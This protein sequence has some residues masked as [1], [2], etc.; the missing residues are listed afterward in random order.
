MSYRG[1]GVDVARTEPAVPALPGMVPSLPTLPLPVVPALPGM[2]STA[3]PGG[4]IVGPP[5]DPDPNAMLPMRFFGIARRIWMEPP[6]VVTYGPS[7]TVV[8]YPA[9]QPAIN[10]GALVEYAKIT[11]I[12]TFIGIP[13]AWFWASARMHGQMTR[14]SRRR[15]RRSR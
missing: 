11:A 7:Q 3:M 2:P 14:N 13:I 4:G 9:G 5:I 6:P 8:Q 10:Y 15:R 1:L 12:G